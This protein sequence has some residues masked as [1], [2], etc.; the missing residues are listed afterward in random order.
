M[1]RL[2]AIRPVAYVS[3]KSNAFSTRTRS[4]ERLEERGEWKIG[5]I[6]SPYAR[7]I[8]GILTTFSVDF[9]HLRC[10]SHPH[11]VKCF[12][13]ALRSQAVGVGRCSW[14]LVVGTLVAARLRSAISVDLCGG[15]GLLPFRA[16][17]Q[18]SHSRVGVRWYMRVLFL[19]RVIQ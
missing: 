12:A 13:C 18:C 14:M 11:R 6:G 10:S 8:H 2:C 9:P 7:R 16:T 17:P 1:N 15:R 4:W 19:R 5:T 3:V